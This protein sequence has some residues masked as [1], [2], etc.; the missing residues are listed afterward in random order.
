MLALRKDIMVTISHL[1]FLSLVHPRERSE[2]VMTRTGSVTQ[3]V[4][5]ALGWDLGLY[6]MPPACNGLTAFGRFKPSGASSTLRCLVFFL[7]P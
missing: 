1:Q 3:S 2:N 7:L 5:D 6:G 4:R